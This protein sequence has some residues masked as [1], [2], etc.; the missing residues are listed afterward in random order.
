MS[1]LALTGRLTRER[2]LELSREIIEEAGEQP[3]L[4]ASV[5]MFAADD[6]WLHAAMVGIRTASLPSPA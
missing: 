3:E 4:S 1:R 5:E 2:Y 6:E